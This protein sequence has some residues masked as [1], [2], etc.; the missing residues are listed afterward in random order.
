MKARFKD[1]RKSAVPEPQPLREIRELAESVWE[2]QRDAQEFLSTP[3]ALLDGR[4]P[5]AVARTR[6]G[7]ERV[8]RILLSLEYGLPG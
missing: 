6:A 2:N 5:A 7:A 1:A 3:H 8:R 4:T